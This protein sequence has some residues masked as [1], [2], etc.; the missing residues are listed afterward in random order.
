MKSLF[1][2]NLPWSVKDEDL[3]AQFSQFGNV[4]AARVVTDKFTGKSRGFGFVDM[5]DATADDAI[6]KMNGFKWE[7]REITVNVAQPKT[8]RRE[9]GFDGGKKRFNRF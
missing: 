6:S 3:K 2:G 8:E 1:V 7:S 9:G 5:D 4:V